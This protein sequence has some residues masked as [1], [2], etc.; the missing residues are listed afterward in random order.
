MDLAIHE[1]NVSGI[2]NEFIFLF[3]EENEV[4]LYEGLKG[5]SHHIVLDT[6]GASCLPLSPTYVFDGEI[7]PVLFLYPQSKMQK[8][9]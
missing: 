2:Q 7:D 5:A 8:Q 9:I 3:C 1:L 6:F 4:L